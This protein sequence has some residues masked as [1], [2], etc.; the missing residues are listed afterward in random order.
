MDHRGF[1]PVFYSQTA[2][3]VEVFL[4]TCPGILKLT[5]NMNSLRPPTL[6]DSCKAKGILSET[7][8]KSLFHLQAHESAVDALCK[9][10]LQRLTEIVDAYPKVTG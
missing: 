5:R 2:D 10:E 1:T 7:I 4:A 8:E 3:V 9:G 6:L